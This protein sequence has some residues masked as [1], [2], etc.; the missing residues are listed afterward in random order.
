MERNLTRQ[1]GM[2][3][4]D[5]HNPPIHIFGC[6]S[7][8]SH[9]A[10]TLAKTGF[11]NITVYDFDE[12][13]EA[14]IYPQMFKPSQIGKLKTESIKETIKEFTNIDI[15]IVN[16]K[17]TEQTEIPMQND[18]Y[19]VLAFDSLEA[20]KLVYAKL[21]DLPIKL[22][23]ARIGSFNFRIYFITCDKKEHIDFYE[24]TF[25]GEVSDLP[26]GEKSM[27]YINEY[28]VSMITNFIVQDLNGKSVP[29]RF[30]GRMTNKEILTDWSK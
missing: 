21:K 10:F 17:I 24:K 3:N 4:P 22:L 15:E 30:I 13:D 1:I 29:S 18:A 12:V 7:I 6:G 19:Y 23:D 14:N 26:C 8:G 27:N 9:L 2:F 28:V 20:R 11:T 25:K 16:E 5:E